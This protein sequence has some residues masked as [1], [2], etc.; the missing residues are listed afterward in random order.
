MLL[1]PQTT[2][3]SS[4]HD[5]AVDVGRDVTSTSRSSS[6]YDTTRSSVALDV[7]RMVAEPLRGIAK[8]SRE[9]L[10]TKHLLGRVPNVDLSY[11]DEDE[12]FRAEIRGVARGAT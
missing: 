3:R 6:A 2:I 7:G 1:G 4:Q 10:Q 11:S 12:A 5:A 8:Q 9:R